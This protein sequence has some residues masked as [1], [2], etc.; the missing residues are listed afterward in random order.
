MEAYITQFTRYGE[1]KEIKVELN[2]V[3]RTIFHDENNLYIL[4]SGI[5]EEFYNL[6]EI[7]HKTLEQKNSF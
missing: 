3:D 7:N 5:K 6:V 4:K 2:D 1:K